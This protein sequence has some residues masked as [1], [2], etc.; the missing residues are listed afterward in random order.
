M[1]WYKDRDFPEIKRPIAGGPADIVGIVESRESLDKII[2]THNEEVEA[3]QFRVT[4]LSISLRNIGHHVQS[5]RHSEKRYAEV[6]KTHYAFA[7]LNGELSAIER[8]LAAL[9]K[10]EPGSNPP[11]SLL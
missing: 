11:P 2:K 4:E 7:K 6:G 1:S 10:A 8:E 3:L 9:K 5:V